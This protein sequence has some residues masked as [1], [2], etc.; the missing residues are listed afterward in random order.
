MP[1]E[2]QTSRTP[3]E[4]RR[5]L[6]WIEGDWVGGNPPIMG[7][8]TNAAWIGGVAPDLA[9]H[10]KRC[11]ASAR[12][13]GLEPPV[14]ADEI[15][16]RAWEGIERFGAEE[17]IY[18]RPMF[19]AEDGFVSPKPESTRFVLTLFEAPMPEPSG[20]TAHFSKLRRPSPETAPTAAKAACLYPQSAAALR[21]AR[22]AGF[23][24]AVM[25]DLNGNVA[26]F[27]TANIFIAR[28]GR[29]ATPV[30]NGTFLNGITRQRVIKLLTA[31]GIEV[32]E[33]TLT[34]AD[35]IEA[36]EVFSTGNYAKVTPL[37]KLEDREMQPG[38]IY[39]TARESY[40]DWAKGERRP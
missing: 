16:A 27:A 31:A 22:V 24:N 7:P 29:A 30:P 5:K 2:P 32:Q 38:P 1:S 18:I 17:D 3:L 33:A 13:L 36:D 40:F 4:E 12:V 25:A 6:H 39:R 35:V 28:N 21:A 26:E 34:F 15:V 9:S 14:T 20:F 11:V 23:G 19:Y 8:M 10:A 37:I